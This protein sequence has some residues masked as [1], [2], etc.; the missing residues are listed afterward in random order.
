M[1]MGHFQDSDNMFSDF[2]HLGLNIPLYILTP[3]HILEGKSD[4]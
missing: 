3:F 4:R 2:N 1:H